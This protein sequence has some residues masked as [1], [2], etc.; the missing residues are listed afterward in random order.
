MIKLVPN[1]QLLGG[2]IV[3]DRI[4][5]THLGIGFQRRTII[6]RIY[7]SCVHRLGGP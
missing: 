2:D 1:Q 3:L 5:V 6:D 4:I 7:G